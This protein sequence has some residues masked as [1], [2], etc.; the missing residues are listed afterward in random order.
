MNIINAEFKYP[1]TTA[2]YLKKPYILH[3]Y[4]I[5]YVFYEILNQLLII[6]AKKNGKML[7][8]KIKSDKVS[9]KINLI[10]IFLI[11]ILQ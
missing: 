7:K 1:E 10:A 2:T 4:D 5:F 8:F 9:I 11:L 3:R 6:N